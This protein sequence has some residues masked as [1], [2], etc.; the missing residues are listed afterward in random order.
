MRAKS[1]L[2]SIDRRPRRSPQGKELRRG[3]PHP[4]RAR[5]HGHRP[6]GREG[7]ADRRT[8][9]HLGGEAMS[10]APHSASGLRLASPGEADVLSY[11]A[12][13]TRIAL[14][15]LRTFDARGPDAGATARH[16]RRLRRRATQAVSLR[17]AR[18]A[19]RVRAEPP[20]ARFERDIRARSARSTRPALRRGGID[21]GCPA[22]ARPYHPNY[23]VRSSRSWKGTTMRGGRT[24]LPAA[25]H[26]VRVLRTAT[27][28]AETPLPRCKVGEGSRTDDPHPHHRRLPVRRGALCAA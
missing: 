10:A 18:T 14:R 2:S 11:A 25:P 7:P 17:I 28:D 27:A 8:R 12:A 26:Q 16:C 6:Q 21:D 4:R 20:H 15:D 9:H 3:R 1:E 23:Y 19:C 22:N 24:T 13:L 5:R